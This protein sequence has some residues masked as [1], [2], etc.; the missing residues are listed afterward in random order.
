MVIKFANLEIG[1][2]N[3]VVGDYAKL[4]ADIFSFSRFF[5]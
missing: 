5:T 1:Y 3:D 4:G 2:H